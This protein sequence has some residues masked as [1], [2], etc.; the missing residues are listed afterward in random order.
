MSHKKLSLMML[1]AFAGIGLAMI[2]YARFFRIQKHA[3]FVNGSQFFPMLLGGMIVLFCVVSAVATVMRTEDEIIVIPNIQ[4]IL[5][6]LA[7]TLAWVACWQYIGYFYAFSFFFV[8]FLIF[9]FNPAPASLMK[10]RDTL[11]YDGVIITVVY[12]LFTFGL[13]TNL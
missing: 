7:V 6:T 3:L 11:M 1:A 8:G 13:K 4:N 5:L 9:R 12:I 10:L 2:Y